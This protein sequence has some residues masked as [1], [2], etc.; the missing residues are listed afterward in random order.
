M[1][2]QASHLAHHGSE[3]PQLRHFLPHEFQV[4][5]GNGALVMRIAIV[6]I[7]MHPGAY[8]DFLEGGGGGLK[9][10]IFRALTE[11]YKDPA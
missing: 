6:L 3:S 4:Q 10:L 2:I 1:V 8:L 7:D 5:A 9:K 11:H